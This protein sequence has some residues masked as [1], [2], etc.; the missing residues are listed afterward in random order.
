MKVSNKYPFL[1]P[2]RL[3]FLKQ[4][5]PV[6]CLVLLL[7]YGCQNSTPSTTADQA[8]TAE[9]PDTVSTVTIQEGGLSQRIIPDE[10][11]QRTPPAEQVA[12]KT[13]QSKLPKEKEAP[14]QSNPGVKTPETIEEFE[15]NNPI[16]EGGE[17]E[18]INE[19]KQLSS[20]ER[21]DMLA[22]KKMAEQAGSKN[23]AKSFFDKG[24]ENEQAGD[25]QFLLAT[26]TSLFEAQKLYRTAKEFYKSATDAANA[27]KN[28]AIKAEAENART[29][30]SNTKQ[31]LNGKQAEL[32][33]LPKYENAIEFESIAERHFQQ[34]NYEAARNA[35]QQAKNLFVDALNEAKAAPPPVKNTPVVKEEVKAA[36]D[37]S[38]TQRKIKIML[39]DYANGMETNDLNS[40]RS[41]GFITSKE[42]AGWD[43]FFKNVK[44]LTVKI[45]NEKFDINQNQAQV[46]FQVKMSYFNKSKGKRE[47]NQFPKQWK[48]EATNGN[49]KI[50]S[51]N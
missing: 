29:A 24:V 20:V 2:Q 44:D 38:V 23:L 33:G 30:L 9:M 12:D 18:L 27:S 1:N 6:Y 4:I 19:L 42:Q 31:S 45:D 7:A 50:V 8:P 11:K 39:D 36:E 14:I 22:E 41:K 48:L 47:D 15:K 51:L 28:T 26:R 43:Q 35:F 25:Q 13:S 3:S 32:K 34:Q 37:N 10:E 49:W 40:L 16:K 5:T 17:S 46:N 21:T